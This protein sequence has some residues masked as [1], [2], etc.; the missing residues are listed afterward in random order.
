[1]L[2]RQVIFGDILRDAKD[3]FGLAVLVLERKRD[4]TKGAHIAV[5]PGKGMYALDGRCFIQH[6]A[7]NLSVRGKLR[8]K[9]ITIDMA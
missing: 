2:L 9:G 8:G 7:V 4:G 5:P 1:M 6:S 3:V